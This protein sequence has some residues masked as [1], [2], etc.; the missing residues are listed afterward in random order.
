MGNVLK[1]VLCLLAALIMITVCSPCVFAQSEKGANDD[2]RRELNEK[3]RERLDSGV[4]KDIA[5]ALE[6]EK[7]IITSSRFMG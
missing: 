3:I 7:I 4:P 5:K 1:N 6:K 2:S